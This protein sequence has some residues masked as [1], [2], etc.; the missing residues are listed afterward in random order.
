MRI[1]M[2]RQRLVFGVFLVTFSVVSAMAQDDDYY[3]PET[4]RPPAVKKEELAAKASESPTRR[5][6]PKLSIELNAHFTYSQ[7]QPSPAL[8][9]FLTKSSGGPGCDVGGGIRIR[10]RQRFALSTGVNFSIRQFSMEYPITGILLNG[11]QMRL[12]VSESVAMFFPTIYFRPHWELSKRFYLGPL[13]HFGAIGRNSVNRTVMWGTNPVTLTPNES[14]IID[15]YSIQFDLGVHAG[16]KIHVA[17]QLIIKPSIEL[18]L[19]LAP[20]FHTNLYQTGSRIEENAR[21]IHLRIGV[22][23]ESGLWFDKF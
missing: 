4:K 23:I 12:S 17:E 3:V 15:S 18:G 10:I 19:G 16:Y 2:Y 20:A 8:A 22:V 1:A 7:F 21:F 13:I 5:Y 11:Q 9:T 6:G 14:P